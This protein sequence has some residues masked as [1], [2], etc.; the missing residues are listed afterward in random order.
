[1]INI[2]I[3]VDNQKE[4]QLLVKRHNVLFFILFYR[5]TLRIK[6]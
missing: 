3:L 5:K 2:H 1:M 6:G 4:G